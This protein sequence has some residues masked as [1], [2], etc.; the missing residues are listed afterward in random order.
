MVFETEKQ[1]RS[2]MR[3]A[4]WKRPHG[5]EFSMVFHRCDYGQILLSGTWRESL[6]LA[7]RRISNRND[8]IGRRTG[9]S[10]R[11]RSQSLSRMRRNEYSRLDVACLHYFTCIYQGVDLDAQMQ[12]SVLRQNL[13]EPQTRDK[14][15][16]AGLAFLERSCSRS[17]RNMLKEPES[18]MQQGL[19]AINR[20][21][22]PC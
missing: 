8:K 13:L 2:C 22:S 14:R 3:R 21:L 15:L 7:G 18:W 1:V 10:H 11:A 4:F 19:I 12:L 16:L 17:S 6:S 9:L 20:C 5:S